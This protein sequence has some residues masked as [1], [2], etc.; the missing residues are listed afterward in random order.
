MGDDDASTRAFDEFRAGLSALR[1]PRP[2]IALVESL[3]P[4]GGKTLKQILTAAR[5]VFIRDGHA[6][7]S[8]RKVADE[9]AL[10]VGNVNYYFDSKRALL[11]ATLREALADYVDA[12]IAQ[13]ERSDGAPLDILLD[14]VTF[15]VSNARASHGLFFQM[16]G[17]AASDEDGK[18][19]VRDLYR[20]VGRLIYPLVRAA[21]PDASE[22]RLR[23][24]VLQLFSLEE[25]VKLFIGL[26]PDN[27]PALLAAERHTRA[28]AQKL[29]L[30]E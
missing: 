5:E 17:Y 13:V 12:H 15:Y 8:L 11:E 24:I 9:A 7:L 14:I 6:G 4:K 27:Q 10:S 26:G 28:L 30:A 2:S 23:E 19:L 25:G 29:I 21:R 1:P 20:S 18:A 22:E 3:S 16:W